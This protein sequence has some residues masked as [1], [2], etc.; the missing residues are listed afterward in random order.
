MSFYELY[1]KSLAKT[2]IDE[3]ER[4]INSEK[5]WDEKYDLIFSNEISKQFLAVHP[6][7]FKEASIFQ[8]KRAI[9]T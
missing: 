5:L 9:V 1:Q 3:A 4:I 7:P 8:W 2:I 6:P